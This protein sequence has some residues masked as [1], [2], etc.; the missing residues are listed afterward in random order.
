MS[1]YTILILTFQLARVDAA[2]V[3]V[4]AV[5]V[6]SRDPTLGWSLTFL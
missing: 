5:G 2:A 4:V 3:V 1:G 6:A